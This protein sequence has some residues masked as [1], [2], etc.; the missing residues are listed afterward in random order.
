MLNQSSIAG[1]VMMIDEVQNRASEKNPE[2]HHDLQKFVDEYFD[3]ASPYWDA[4]Y[5]NTDLQSTIYRDRQTLALKL[6]DELGLPNHAKVL[7]IGCGAGMLTKAI[8]HRGYH[9]SALDSAPAMKDLTDR[10]AKAAGLSNFVSTSLEDVH[11]L[12]FNDNTFDMAFALGV[13]PWLHSPEKAMQEIQRVVKPGGYFIVTI[14]NKWRLNHV[15]DPRWNPALELPRR[16][17]KSLLE[18]LRLRK[19]K[20]VPVLARMHSPR[21]LDIMLSSLGLTKL[22]GMTLGFGPF[23]LMGKIFIPDQL[24]KR[25]NR[26]FQSLADHRVPVIRSTGSHYIIVGQR[27]AEIKKSLEY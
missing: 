25:I 21:E 17:A 19:P 26:F 4:I 11:D 7:E 6:L 24:G 23:M 27:P 5:N 14:D 13:L 16:A 20:T 22:K 18:T 2:V 9:V 8:A 3:N 10:R 1:N 12:S 15:L